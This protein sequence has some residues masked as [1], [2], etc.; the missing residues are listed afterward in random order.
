MRSMQKGMHA[1]RLA[2][3]SSQDQPSGEVLSLGSLGDVNR[4]CFFVAGVV[5]EMLTRVFRGVEP[6]FAPKPQDSWRFGLFLQK[7]NILKD[8]ATDEREGRRLV[9]SRR[10]LLHSA[11]LDAEAAWRY[12]QAIPPTWP[13]YQLFCGWSFFLG[14]ETLLRMSPA[15]PSESQPAPSRWQT[16]ELI[17]QIENDLADPQAWSLRAQSLMKQLREALGEISALKTMDARVPWPNLARA[18]QGEFTL[19]DLQSLT[20]A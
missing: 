3:D 2:V 6:A 11:I 17:A 19:E 7:V 14:L 1:F 5:G 20:E 13:G 4:Y 18:Y 15:T 8:Q 16:L 10:A 9:P 12:L